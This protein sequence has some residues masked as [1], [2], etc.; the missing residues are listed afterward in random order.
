MVAT[1][2]FNQIIGH[3]FSNHSLEIAAS[4]GHYVLMDGPPGCGKSLLAE[5][6]RAIQS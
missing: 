6:F 5:T 3:D 2:D 4:G 1:S